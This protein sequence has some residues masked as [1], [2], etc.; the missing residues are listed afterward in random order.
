MDLETI[1]LVGTV[2]G[3]IATVI[4]LGEKFFGYGK[5]AYLSFKK[6]NSGRLLFKKEVFRR[7]GKEEVIAEPV[8]QG[9]FNSH[10]PIRKAVDLDISVYASHHSRTPFLK[11]IL[12]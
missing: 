9:S 11:T 7:P 5:R 6:I 8:F 4:T 3:A 12:T 1:K 10:T 2:L